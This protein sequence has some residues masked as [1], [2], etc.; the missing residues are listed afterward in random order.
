MKDAQAW[1]EHLKAHI[2]LALAGT[3]PEGVHQVRVAARRLRVYLDLLGYRV[4]RDD[5]RRLARGTGRV[6]DLEVVLGRGPFP[7][8]FQSFLERELAAARSRLPDLLASPW[9]EVLLRA[10]AT[11]PPLQERAA[12]QRLSRLEK[13]LRKR[14]ELLK[15]DPSPEAFHA[16]RKALRRLRY[17]KEFLGLPAK[18]EKRLQDRLGEVQDLEVLLALLREYL[19]EAQDGE[20]TRL[21]EA[22]GEERQRRLV[23]LQKALLGE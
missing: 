12:F 18:E 5:L 14:L 7:E 1:R 8:G 17:A 2:P 4:L 15:R 10:L 9:T 23:A 16:Y 3:D 11:L 20:A 21:A 13:G 19:L 22:L 6:R